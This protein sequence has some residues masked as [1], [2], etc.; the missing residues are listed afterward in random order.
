MA[1]LTVIERMVM[2]YYK[3]ESAGVADE[4]EAMLAA[5]R[6]LMRCAT[7]IGGSAQDVVAPFLEAAINE[8]VSKS[9]RFPTQTRHRS[10]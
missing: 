1:E 2:A 10:E 3:A 8:Q 5:V 4:T 7:K 9:G 6:E